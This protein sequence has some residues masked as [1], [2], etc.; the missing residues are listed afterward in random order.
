[1]R[2][3]AYLARGYE[4]R[5]RKLE[6]ETGYMQRPERRAMGV[7]GLG[8]EWGTNNSEKDGEGELSVRF[9]IEE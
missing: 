3:A 7:G 6:A 2:G 9:E 5:V 4:R 8:Q 1:M